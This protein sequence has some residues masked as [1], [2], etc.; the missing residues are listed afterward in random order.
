MVPQ[1]RVEGYG[2]LG[3]HYLYLALA[4]SLPVQVNGNDMQCTQCKRECVAAAHI[5]CVVHTA[6]ALLSYSYCL[7]MLVTTRYNECDTTVGSVQLRI[8]GEGVRH[9]EL[10]LNDLKTKFKR[11]S[12]QA[13]MQ[14]SGNRRNGMS[15][16]K[17]IQGLGWD[18]GEPARSLAGS[19]ISNLTINGVSCVTFDWHC[20]K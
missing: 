2:I 11:H 5:R 18:I 9:V 1:L 6:R 10:S 16:V 4:L 12:V 13:A 15:Q 7:C 8:E 14:C 17:K 3:V 20:A 19:A